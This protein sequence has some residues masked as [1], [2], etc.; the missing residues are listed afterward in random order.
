MVKKGYAAERLVAV[1]VRQLLNGQ[2]LTKRDHWRAALPAPLHCYQAS[3]FKVTCPK[4]QATRLETTK[5][6]I[7]RSPLMCQRANPTD[8]A[9]TPR[10]P[11]WHIQD[12]G[13][14]PTMNLPRR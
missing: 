10:R 9:F 2:S 5:V 14:G 13:T 12:T 8:N 7:F 4:P 3:S 1:G 6:F 11:A